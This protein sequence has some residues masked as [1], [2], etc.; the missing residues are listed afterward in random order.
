[1]SL[2]WLVQC[3]CL[4]TLPSQASCFK[5]STVIPQ[6]TVC[7]QNKQSLSP[8]GRHIMAPL[9]PVHV[10]PLFGIVPYVCFIRAGSAVNRKAP[11]PL[12]KQSSQLQVSPEVPFSDSEAGM[13]LDSFYRSLI[14]REYGYTM[15]RCSTLTGRLPE[16]YHL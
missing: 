4:F 14:L 12:V 11:P 13:R 10:F 15:T 8:K 5:T 7:Q 9:F 1:M 2:C 16:L 3:M 6:Q